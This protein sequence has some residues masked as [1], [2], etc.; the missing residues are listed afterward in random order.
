M[1][2]NEGC[3]FN[4]FIEKQLMIDLRPYPKQV[5]LLEQQSRLVAITD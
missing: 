2:R 5:T 3:A 4:H 1:C